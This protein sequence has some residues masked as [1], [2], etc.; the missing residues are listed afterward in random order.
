MTEDYYPDAEI[1]KFLTE[2]KSLNIEE[3]KKLE[4]RIGVIKVTDSKGLKFFGLL[5]KPQIDTNLLKVHVRKCIKILASLLVKFQ[6][7]TLH[8]TRDK[9]IMKPA[10][11]IDLIKL[12]KK[13]FLNKLINITFFHKTIKVPAVEKREKLIRLYHESPIAGQ[14][15]K[16]HTLFRRKGIQE[17]VNYIVKYCKKC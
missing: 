2:K 7:K 5:V 1:I 9:E 10:E 12:C 16:N 11:V 6:F 14:R 8:K 13:L 17:A 3:L 15:G 4:P